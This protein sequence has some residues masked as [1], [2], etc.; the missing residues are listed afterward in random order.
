[1]TNNE[2]FTS[3][4]GAIYTV[5]DVSTWTLIGGK[6]ITTGRVNS[7]NPSTG[8]GAS[9]GLSADAWEAYKR[10]RV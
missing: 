1:M 10:A 2:T 3:R 4:G 5:S 9:H 8:H 7:Y 6:Q